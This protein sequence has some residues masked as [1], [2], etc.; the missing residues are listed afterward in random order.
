MIPGFSSGDWAV[1]HLK[2]FLQ[3]QGYRVYT[4]G[5]WYNPGPTPR[6][7]RRLHAA[8]MRL[9]DNTKVMLIGISLGGMLARDLALRHPGRVRCVVTVCSPV[10]VPVITPLAPFA[11][12]LAP[13][14]AADW[15][16]RRHR[17]ANPL[18]V[19]VT[20]LHAVH[21][22]VVLRDQCW[23]DDTGNARNVVVAG[24]HMTLECTPPGLAAVAEALAGCV[25][26]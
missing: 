19:P 22:G 14:Y 24:R 15:V 5:I 17:I 10:R 25:I 12:V 13:F 20:A 9:S 8:F 1:T 26:C 23:L 2:H 7:T 3:R 6:L 16:A 4:A 11:A 21:D 18:P